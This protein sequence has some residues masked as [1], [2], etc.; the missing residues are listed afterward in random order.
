MNRMRE[1]K[2]SS[3]LMISID[4]VPRHQIPSFYKQWTLTPFQGLFLD[5]K[6]LPYVTTPIMRV[7]I[8]PTGVQ[9]RHRLYAITANSARISGTSQIQSF[10]SSFL[11]MHASHANNSLPSPRQCS[12]IPVFFPG[13]VLFLGVKNAGENTLLFE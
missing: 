9:T 8:S 6:L 7:L 3:T 12:A 4:P 10:H 5:P 2:V 1:M 13:Y 11:R